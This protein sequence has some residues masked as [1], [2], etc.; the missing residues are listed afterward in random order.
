MPLRGPG[1]WGLNGVRRG[2]YLMMRR[3][4]TPILPTEVLDDATGVADQT[5]PGFLVQGNYR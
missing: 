5:V 3:A 2:G 4:R 1:L